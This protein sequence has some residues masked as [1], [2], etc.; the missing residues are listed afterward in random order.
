MFR[1]FGLDFVIYAAVKACVMLSA[2]LVI[3][4]LSA[5]LLPEEFGA[6]GLVMS[7]LTT[8]VIL[9]STFLM[10]SILRYFPRALEKG[11]IR[12]FNYVT[13][14]IGQMV[15]VATG[16]LTAVALAILHVTGAVVVTPLL[17]SAVI[18]AALGSALF[19]LYPLYL[20]AKREKIRYSKTIAL[21]TLVFVAALVVSLGVFQ[22]KLATIFVALAASQATIYLIACPK[23]RFFRKIQPQTRAAF[24]EYRRYGLP[25]VLLHV[26]IQMNS[27][28]DQYIIRLFGDLHSVGLYAANYTLGE[29]TIYGLSSITALA[30]TP[31]LFRQW[32][33]GNHR[34]CYINLWRFF[35]LLLGFGFLVFVL[36]ALW[37]R[38]LAGYV[39]APNYIDGAAILPCVTLG[40]V[41]LGGAA[42]LA[43]V[44]T[45]K[46]RTLELALCYLSA[47]VVN[48]VSNLVLVPK[49]G[50]MGAAY[51]TLITY[52]YLVLVILWRTQALVGMFSYLPAA[53]GR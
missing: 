45:L 14:Q 9:S 18:A 53:V 10:T 8:T 37:G 6:Y 4:I 29:K 35:L 11:R 47:T 42:I 33:R 22:D 38:T 23:L 3:K 50:Y 26:S 48:L 46:E 41:C 32:E 30:V 31:H 5:R 25:V 43:E 52:V 40:A 27:T 7:A 12:A 1:T 21:Q 24:S 44:F 36:F 51:A 13:T 19:Q 17:A 39:L 28:L 49:F 34:D 15:M 2:F 16:G 20:N